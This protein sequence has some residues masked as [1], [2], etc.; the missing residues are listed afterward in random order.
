MHRKFA[1]LVKAC[2]VQGMS[3]R[4]LALT[5][6]LGAA[7]GMLPVIW[8]STLLCALLAF[9]LKLNQAII[10]AANYLVYPVQIALIFPFYRLGARIFPWG[11]AVSVNVLRQ[12]LAQDWT[13]DIQLLIVATLKALAAWLIMAPPL[14]ALIYVL[15]LTILRRLTPDRGTPC[16][17][18]LMP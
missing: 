12:R 6:A 5:L 13:G 18:H 7:V 17:G 2:L 14:V 8:G 10:Q 11:P 15:V 3:P 9:R 4:R 16:N 1:K